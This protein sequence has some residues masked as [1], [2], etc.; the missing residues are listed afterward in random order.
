MFSV[1]VAQRRAVFSSRRR[2]KTSSN[3]PATILFFEIEY[4]AIT[5]GRRMPSRMNGSG[6][7]ALV[8][9]WSW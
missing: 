4:Y 7:G 2:K 1:S 6:T 3:Q 5:V 8:S 9:V